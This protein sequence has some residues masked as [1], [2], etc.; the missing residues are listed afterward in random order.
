MVDQ[1]LEKT[2]YRLVDNWVSTYNPSSG[3][4]IQWPS[5]LIP[6]V[7]K[8][9]LS[10]SQLSTDDQSTVVVY[11]FNRLKKYDTKF[12]D[13]FKI[14]EATMLLSIDFTIGSMLIKATLRKLS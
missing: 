9:R 10:I 7:E 11:I 5:A 13:V 4:R 2:L 3:M 12:P 8:L 14:K 1:T 6:V